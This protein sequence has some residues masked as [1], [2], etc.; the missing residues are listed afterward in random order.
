MLKPKSGLAGTPDPNWPSV[1]L[2]AIV[3]ELGAN[4]GHRFQPCWNERLSSRFNGRRKEGPVVRT[5]GRCRASYGGR[6]GW[7]VRCGE[8]H[9]R[10]RDAR[11]EIMRFMGSV[12]VVPR[13]NRAATGPR[14]GQAA[15]R[16][17]FLGSFLRYW[18]RLTSS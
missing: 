12:S 3:H 9:P 4:W 1:A 13:G 17:M 11:G 18:C 10:G 2:G 5:W 7:A 15:Y 8:L 14:H 16:P 6:T